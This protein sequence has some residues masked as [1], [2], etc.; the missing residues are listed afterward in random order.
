[1]LEKFHSLN[2]I[3]AGSSRPDVAKLLSRLKKEG[4]V[5]RIAPRVY[6]TNLTDSPENIVR[7]NIWAIVGSLW[8]GARLS[9]RTAFEYA[10]HEGHIFL[11]YKY[12]RKVRLPGVTIHFLATPDSL[13]S[14]YPFLEHLG[15]SSHARALLENLEPDKTQGGVEKCLGVESLEERLEAEFGSGGEAALNRLRDEAREVAE[16][17]CGKVPI[18]HSR[19]LEE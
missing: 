15:V 8:P 11:G 14:D 9:H 2:E 18:K 7:R 6:T 5:I 3:I 1:M 13:E 19:V 17:I 16:D 12:T 10:P 4:K